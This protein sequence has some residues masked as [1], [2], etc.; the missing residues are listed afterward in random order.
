MKRYKN[1]SQHT[2]SLLAHVQYW[3]TM[4]QYL[5]QCTPDDL[6]ICWSS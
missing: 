4:T 6:T 3:P 1:S 5:H 2:S